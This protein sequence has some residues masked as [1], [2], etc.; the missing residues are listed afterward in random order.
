MFD[1]TFMLLIKMISLKT[2][3]IV[4]Y[5]KKHTNTKAVLLA[6]AQLY[7]AETFFAW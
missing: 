7:T 5:N 2:L 6:G 4:E 3:L 1:L